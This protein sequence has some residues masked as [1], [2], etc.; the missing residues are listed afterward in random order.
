MKYT[1]DIY[2]ITHAVQLRVMKDRIGLGLPALIPT[3]EAAWMMIDAI[4]CYEHG[5]AEPTDVDPNMTLEMYAKVAYDLI[6]VI[7]AQS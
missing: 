1:E 5:N 3:H 7:Q 6:S 2:P 4:G